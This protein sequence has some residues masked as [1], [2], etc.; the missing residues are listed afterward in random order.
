MTD[1]PRQLTET[2]SPPDTAPS[3]TLPAD[4]V[5]TG[6]VGTGPQTA[7]SEVDRAAAFTSGRAPVDRAA[8]LRAG[9]T[10]IPRKFFMWVIIGFAVLGIGGLVAER[11]V[12]NSGV[13]TVISTPVTT[14]PGTGNSAPP[15]PQTP[16]GPS[17]PA[18]PA[19]VIG[20]QHLTGG[21][22]PAID[23]HTQAG[24]PW[25]LADARGRVVVL[26]FF[27]AE[28]NDICP[29][30]AA[31]ITQ[32]DLLLGARRADVEFV[33]VNTDPLETSLS[34]APP[35]LSQT[36]LDHLANVTYLTGTLAD[37]SH[38]WKSYGISVALSNTTR[39]VS[40]NDIMYFITSNGRLTLHAIPFANESSLGLYSLD[41]A[42]MHT[43]ARGIAAAATGLVG[44]SS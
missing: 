9:S 8:A 13:E 21:A 5:R 26:S 3:D 40:H 43:F 32:A 25:T 27:N 24:V 19:A 34:V 4:S 12:G 38:V 36:G 31:E 37:L 10:P 18:S 2:P 35:A 23:L 17:V 15:T 39:V 41:P 20:L 42:T 14:L 44:E 28:C 33:V 29:V 11:L 1:D 6:T 7:M 16:T 30:L 22:A